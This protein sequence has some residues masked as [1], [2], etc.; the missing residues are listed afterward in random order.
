M[1]YR[2]LFFL[3][4]VTGVVFCQER[5]LDASVNFRK[6]KKELSASELKKLDAVSDSLHSASLS[7][8]VIKGFTDSDADSVYNYKL[9]A[10][11]CNEVRDHLLLRGADPLLIQLFPMGEELASGDEN[12]AIKLKNRRV[13]VLLL[14]KEKEK[15]PE[16]EKP[17]GDCG[18]D[19][20]VML[21]Q[22]VVAVF[23]VCEYRKKKDCIRLKARKDVRYDMKL[24]RFRMKLGLKNYYKIKK[25]YTSYTVNFTCADTSCG[26]V[27]ASLLVPFF[28]VQEKEY[29]ALKFD[30]VSMSYKDIKGAKIKNVQK[31]R[32]ISIPNVNCNA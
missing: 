29:K 24:S 15:T 4:I 25:K 1:K 13:D 2:L 16:K 9:S 26:N 8:I 27:N 17:A 6:N 28:Q 3:L 14:F 7:A 23:K 21:E 32:Y 20:T 18:R 31:K 30:S 11:R 12:E 22:G 19:T 10:G 5:V